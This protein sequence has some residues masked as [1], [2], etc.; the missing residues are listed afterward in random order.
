MERRFELAFRDFDASETFGI[1][2]Q[3]WRQLH[4]LFD[5]T[6]NL[7]RVWIF[8]SRA[9]GKARVNS[10]ID[11]A[12]DAPRM[13]SEAAHRLILAIDDLPTL[14]RI[15][16]IHWQGTTDPVL[17]SEIER[18]RQTLWQSLRRPVETHPAGRE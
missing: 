11:I 17:R 12:F 3:S 15:D 18:D 5:A 1:S 6:A 16:A 4:A 13:S 10:D 9:T 14:Y 2:A 8:G 7:D